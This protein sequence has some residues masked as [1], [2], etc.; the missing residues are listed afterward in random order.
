M[1]TWPFALCWAAGRAG[2]CPADSMPQGLTHRSRPT[3]APRGLVW[4]ESSD[5]RAQEGRAGGAGGRLGGDLGRGQGAWKHL[6]LPV[7]QRVTLPA[8]RLVM[9][10]AGD[11]SRPR[12]G[13]EHALQLGRSM[14]CSVFRPRQ[15]SPSSE[16]PCGTSSDSRRG[17]HGS[18]GLSARSDGSSSWARL[19][20]PVGC[21]WHLPPFQDPRGCHWLVLAFSFFTAL[22]CSLVARS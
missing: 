16:Q 4:E 20:D 5:P 2:L 18:R 21:C 13:A 10:A 6:P 8:P 7:S 1:G 12:C 11:S 22:Q 17:N 15:R 3:R 9:V 19:L 14:V